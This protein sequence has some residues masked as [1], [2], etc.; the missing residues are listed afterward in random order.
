M[1][2][3]DAGRFDSATCILVSSNKPI[4]PTSI[5]QLSHLVKEIVFRNLRNDFSYVFAPVRFGNVLK[6]PG[7]VIFKFRDPIGGGEP[8]RVTHPDVNEDSMSIPEAI[9]L[10]LQRFFPERGYFVLDISATVPMIVV[11]KQMI[12]LCDLSKIGTLTLF[13]LISD[14]TKTF[15]KSR[16]ITS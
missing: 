11:S 7:F 1:I 9:T 13:S 15:L 4:N 16:F 14:P 6:S 10:V 12:E 3:P 5:I 2:G 8:V